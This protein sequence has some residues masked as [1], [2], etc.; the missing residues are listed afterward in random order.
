MPQQ[1]RVDAVLVGSVEDVTVADVPFGR[2]PDEAV[3]GHRGHM[4]TGRRGDALDDVTETARLNRRAIGDR[5]RLDFG[6]EVNRQGASISISEDAV[7]GSGKD[8]D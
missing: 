7:G 3:S 2:C 5:Y 1:R 4:I 6:G 8:G